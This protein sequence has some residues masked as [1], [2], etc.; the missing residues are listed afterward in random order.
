MT[1]N[2]K[3]LT[4]TIFLV[5][6]VFAS[7]LAYGGGGAIPTTTV[8]S[9]SSNSV[10]AGTAVTLTATVSPSGITKGQVLFC[11]ASVARCD[12]VAVLGT[13]QLTSAGTASI[14]LV[15][16]FGSYSIE[17]IFVGFTGVLTSTSAPQTLAV[18]GPVSYP[19]TTTI[20][21]TGDEFDYTLTATVAGFGRPTSNATVSFL[22]TSNGNAPVATAALDPATLGSSFVQAPNSPVASPNAHFV[23]AGDFNHDGIPDL[24]VLNFTNSGKIRVLLGDGDGTFAA[25]T[26]YAVGAYPVA[27][28]TA[29][30]NGDGNLDLV[31][32]N[33]TAGTLSV[34]LGNANGTFQFRSVLP[35]L[36][37]SL[38]NFVA[39]ADFN[40]DGVPDLIA[41]DSANNV[42][43]V[44]L[45]NG[46]GTFAAP[47]PYL[48]GA[49]PFAV[50]VG[51]FNNDGI[52]DLAVSDSGDGFLTILTGVGNGTFNRPLTIT[53]PSGV[54][55][56]WLVS[57]DLR[58]DGNSDLVVPD[59]V[60]STVYVLLS[61]G[62][63]TFQS[64]VAYTVAN[65]PEGVSLGDINGDGVLDLVVPDTGADGL[66]S[67]LMGEGDGT[68]AERKDYTVGDGPT[69]AGLADF[70]GD[71]L[72]DIVTSNQAALNFSVLLQVHTETATAT[73]VTVA[74]AGTHNVRA[75]YPGDANHAASQSTTVPLTGFVV[76]ST[77]T[78]LGA[79][80]N[81]GYTGSPVVLSATVSPTPT[82]ASLGTVS[83]HNG[84]TLLGSVNLNASGVAVFST[85]NLAVGAHSIMAVYS[86]NAGF[87]TSTSPP[88]SET[89]L[90][91]SATTTALTLSSPSVVS[92][93]PV[94]L[95]A[96]VL[97]GSTPATSGTVLFCD[98]TA[99]RCE[100][101]AIF[102]TA[103]LK[104][105]GTAALKLTL[106]VGQ[107]SIDAVFQS[108]NPDQRSVSSA[109][110]LTVA[111]NGS[112]ASTTTIVASGSAGN[113]TLAGT[114]TAFGK[115]A[116][117][118]N[119]SFLDTS[120]SDAVVAAAAFDPA[121]L[122]YGIVPAS[123]SPLEEGSGPYNVVTGDFNNDGILD[124]AVVDN[125]TP[126][127]SVYIGHGD[128]TFAAAVT[129]P[130]NDLGLDIKVGDFNG[131]G[132]LDIVTANGYENNTLSVLLGNGDGTFQSEVAY[133]AGDAPSGVAVG[134]FNHDGILDL[135]VA[136]GDF[137]GTISI[138]LGNGDGTFKPQVR[139]T[140]GDNDPFYI[141]TADFNGDGILDLATVNLA[142][143][144]MSVLIGNGDGSFQSPVSYATGGSPDYILAADVNNDGK[145]DLVVANYD[146][147]TISVYLGNG[148]GTFQTQ[149]IS[150]T[151]FGPNDLVAG[152]FNGD[153]KLDLA[154]TNNNDV[155]VSILFG[156]GLGNFGATQLTV[157]SGD[158]P[159]GIAIGDF[160]G[161]GLPD[162][163]ATNNSDS[164][165]ALWLN[166]KT[167]SATSTGVTV[168]GLGAHNVLAN[169]PGD[170]SRT[171]SQSAT[172][173][174]DGSPLTATS[175]TLVAA[176]N[177]ANLGQSVI[178]AATV[179]PAPTG[180]SL[181]TVNFSDGATLLGS[182][183]VNSSG[184]ATFPT[185]GLLTG[186]HNLTAVYSGNAG[187][188]TSTST[189]FPETITALTSTSTAL[190]AAPNPAA[191]GQAVTLTATVSPVPNGSPLGTVHFFDGE[192]P[193]GSG[194][195]NSSGV[196]TLSSTSFAAGAHSLTAIYSGNSGFADSTSNTFTETI[197]AL[198]STTTTLS[199]APD[200]V[201]DGQLVTLTA[202]VSPAPTGS[203]PGTVT[204]FNG[205][206]LVGMGTL[207][208]S[209]V[210]TFSTTSLP[211]G[212]LSLTAVYSGNSGSTAST[213]S[214]F[215][216]T[217]NPGFTVT[218]PPAPVTVVQ[219]GA[220]DINVTVP[221]LG[222]AFDQRVTLSASGLPPG[223]TASFNPATVT[224]GAG[225]A[226]TVMTIQLAKLAAGVFGEERRTPAGESLFAS[227]F[228]AACCLSGIRRKRWPTQ[229]RLIAFFAVLTFAA[230]TTVGCGGG[231]LSPPTTHSGQYVV[232]ITGTSGSVQASTTVTVVVQ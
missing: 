67:V 149:I 217:V 122:T 83:F 190:A 100:D 6:V 28:A 202:T 93:T 150:A 152:D 38:F 187:F 160:N 132:R 32:A 45:G 116:F 40:R 181:G 26:S 225:G 43:V 198:S 162:L 2:A 186:V 196:A 226:P 139:Y 215:T 146:D 131:D 156:D 118:S 82:G 25:A 111:G 11:N 207:N 65:A 135:A 68:F 69:W 224:P 180:A 61:N 29:D 95:S 133:T 58:N 81:P 54:S 20:T 184:A 178:L 77:T 119:I 96:T 209:G 21:A 87:L 79:A 145:P 53:L 125:N 174:L 98:A 55:P 9:L 165:V 36:G 31:C 185:S 183:N 220:V 208:S 134:D 147:D 101:T 191:V 70:N 182:G 129:Y 113:Y 205:S 80:P 85:T 51:D 189:V 203:S 161:D 117:T 7:P 155:T 27:L 13:A 179:S 72:L 109:Q 24:A 5:L 120:N 33:K 47:V 30:L 195:V 75:S 74:G 197:A 19:T 219:G 78:A 105:N 106:G 59:V 232:T 90:A 41:P 227:L 188:T 168:F 218:A 142:V 151:G 154:V 158:S 210:A 88:V 64:P 56:A 94:T 52:P 71:G 42:V 167:E 206:T 214:P 104:P 148:D 172:A 23:V 89:M 14:K 92:G 50:A 141:A 73:G 102:G 114:V 110:S 127:V 84:A 173:A 46:D 176:P 18:T 137:P 230:I 175:T 63:G 22:D 193:L 200:P 177:P 107:Y 212:I 8:L 10:T 128:G 86:G 136:N 213:S 153:G 192:T 216:E 211:A 91:S 17:A 37:N 49:E 140:A 166:Q 201:D 159:W 124:F 62:D 164:T 48:V 123:G 1:Q 35:G 39:V 121:T 12:G 66:V 170:A 130:I 231:F 3:V 44:W 103:Q 99:A 204:F 223:A 108:T 222:G 97:V 115:S 16:G 4:G 57:G 15:L 229:L 34:L 171:S 143:G 60:S 163:V 157:N 194:N 112:Y 169:Y 221:P 144:T 76:M 138:L 126:T 228:M 199:V